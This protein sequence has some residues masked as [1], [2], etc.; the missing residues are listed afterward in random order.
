MTC[1]PLTFSGLF[2]GAPRPQVSPFI[3]PCL[4]RNVGHTFRAFFF[5]VN[6]DF[7]SFSVFVATPSRCSMA[8]SSPNQARSEIFCYPRNG[9]ISSFCL[10]TCPRCPSLYRFPSSQVAVEAATT[11]FAGAG[12]VVLACT[13]TS[14]LSREKAFLKMSPYCIECWGARARLH[15]CRCNR[16]PGNRRA[17]TTNTTTSN[18]K[19]NTFFVFFPT[20]CLTPMK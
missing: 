2:S 18:N 11:A 7:C 8:T 4:E 1:A 12:G 6:I 9:V 14:I 13:H 20:T 16:E 15:A 17:A 3:L 10:R 5:F 19:H